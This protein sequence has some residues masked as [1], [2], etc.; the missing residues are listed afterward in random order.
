MLLTTSWIFS[1]CFNAI[2]KMQVP[3][4]LDKLLFLVQFPLSVLLC[5]FSP[6]VLILLSDE[7]ENQL[8]HHLFLRYLVMSN[9]IFQFLKTVLLRYF[10]CFSQATCLS[11]SAREYR[12]A[13]ALKMRLNLNN[14]PTQQAWEIVRIAGKFISETF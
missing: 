9:I 4:S 10:S 12:Q 13:L 1:L 11:F 2:S 5:N 8:L 7:R 14:S 3:T 6:L